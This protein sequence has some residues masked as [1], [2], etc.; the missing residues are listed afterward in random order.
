LAALE[1]DIA[2]ADRRLDEAAPPPS[3]TAATSRA[4]R[5]PDCAPRARGKRSIELSAVTTLREHQG[6]RAVRSHGNEAPQPHRAALWTPYGAPER[7]GLESGPC[8]PANR[9]D[10]MA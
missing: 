9:A 8:M 6:R 1:R 10:L 2:G 3:A 5:Q 4:L 7:A